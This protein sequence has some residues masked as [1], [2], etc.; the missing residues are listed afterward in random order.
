MPDPT[1]PLRILVLGPF[2]VEVAGRAVPESAW[3]LRKATS[4]VKLLALA[5]GHRLHREQV[6][7]HFWPELDPSAAVNNFHQVLHAARRALEPAAERR[8]PPTF[9]QL[10]RDVLTLGDPHQVC[11]DLDAFEAAASRARRG[12]IAALE[13]ALALYGGDLLPDDLY[14]DWTLTRRDYARG[15]FVDLLLA[16]AQ[17]R[18]AGGNLAGAADD[19]RRALEAD[20]DRAAAQSAL[21]RLSSLLGDRPPES[22]PLLGNL[23]YDVADFVGRRR[24]VAVVRAL[25]TTHR[26]V[27][28][29]GPGGVG[30]SRL[31]LAAVRAVQDTFP[32]GAWWVDVD[33]LTDGE[34]VPVHL[35]GVLGL[36]TIDEQP[37]LATLM[38]HLRSR[39]VLVVLDGCEHLAAA[40]GTVAAQLLG[41]CPA[42]QMVVT[43]RQPLGVTGEAVWTVP[44]L[45]VPGAAAAL[46]HEEWAEYDAV[47]LFVE[48]ARLRWPDFGLSAATAPPVARICRRLDGLPLAIELAA[49]RVLVLSVEQIAERLDRRLQLLTGGAGP[50]RHQSLLAAIDWSHAL[51]SEP[52]RVLF[53]RLAIFERDWQLADAEQACAAHDLPH[54]T[55]LDVLG[56]LV[57]KSLVVA[58][59]DPRGPTTF[60]ML[61]TIRE[62]AWGELL[63]SGE[64]D[65]FRA[66]LAAAGRRI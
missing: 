45:A 58:Q 20:P 49:A 19:Y 27:T 3:R 56:A 51:L 26:M 13:Q 66:R 63:A 32:G 9:L 16:R 41:A 40:C 5:P 12:E 59:P 15:R 43:S 61:E 37:P 53:R 62:Y 10:S 8:Q 14:E 50:A 46:L 23:P 28:L 2:R 1:S 21:N 52:E 24:E 7:D 35:L 38:D 65:E 25:V 48:R 17:Q 30:K 22:R 60:R 39:R 55:I 64:A 4:L 57:D 29:V 36:L 33:T 47:R 42:L 34:R 44:P 54:H 11:V 18:E 31:A 6:M